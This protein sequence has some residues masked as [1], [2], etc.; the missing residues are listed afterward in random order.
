MV[1]WLQSGRRSWNVPKIGPSH[2]VLRYLYKMLSF[3]CN[4]KNI[5][6]FFC[7]NNFHF[8]IKNNTPNIKYYFYIQDKTKM[9]EGTTFT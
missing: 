3:H 5:N 1:K 8:C 4:S 7:S 9:K 2:P 6:T